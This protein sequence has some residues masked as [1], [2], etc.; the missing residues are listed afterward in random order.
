[1]HP[2]LHSLARTSAQAPSSVLVECAD[3]TS[4][5]SGWSGT[6]FGGNIAAYLSEELEGG[7]DVSNLT[8][9]DG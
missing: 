6:W 3:I 9:S 2:A 1:M 8:V 5:L 4:P 7:C